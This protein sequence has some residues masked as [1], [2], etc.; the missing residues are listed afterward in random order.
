MNP[1][2]LKT[3]YSI[4]KIKIA[5]HW[6]FLSLLAGL[7]FSCSNE[8]QVEQHLSDLKLVDL[9]GK[10]ISPKELEGKKVFL[11]LWAT[12]CRPCIQEMPSIKSAAEELKN[13]NYI[14]L[15]ASEESIDEIKKFASSK[16]FG[17]DLIQIQT[18][19]TK[20]GASALPHTLIF[21]ED[22]ELIYQHTGAATWDNPEML[23]KLF[24]L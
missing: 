2:L 4:T 11:N 23:T 16:D 18:P 21:N 1:D 14:F 19:V 10:V 22:G 7:A 6:F 12:N 3:Y 9:N 24:S 8:N 5:K 20:L 17:L 13:D 15:A